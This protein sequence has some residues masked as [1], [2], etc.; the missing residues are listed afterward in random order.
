MSNIIFLLGPIKV[1]INVNEMENGQEG[2]GLISAVMTS[3][4]WVE[5]GE[6]EL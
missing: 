4:G 2:R 6:E 3:L 5:S 1:K